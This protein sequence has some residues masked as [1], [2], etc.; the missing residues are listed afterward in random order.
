[1]TLPS[2]HRPAR[3]QVQSL[4]PVELQGADVSAEQYM[5]ALPQ[6]GGEWGW[7]ERDHLRMRTPAWGGWV[8]GRLDRRRGR[9]T[10][11]A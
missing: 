11:G 6:V 3:A 1:M 2:C 5:A 10:E 8:D 9:E 4:V 7:G